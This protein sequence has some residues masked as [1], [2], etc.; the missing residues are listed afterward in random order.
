M[1]FAAMRLPP[2][3]AGNSETAVTPARQSAW[4]LSEPE[5]NLRTSLPG[6]ILAWPMCIYH[7][8]VCVP[9]MFGRG[10][11]SFAIASWLLKTLVCGAC[12]VCFHREVFVGCCCCSLLA[13]GALITSPQRLRPA[14]C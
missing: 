11:R 5:Y 14:S 10:E 8:S 9:G 7:R 1:K 6:P 2:P 4:Y 12:Q 3:L 13:S